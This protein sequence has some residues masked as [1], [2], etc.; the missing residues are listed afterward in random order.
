[1]SLLLFT[2]IYSIYLYYINIILN[3]RVT[4]PWSSPYRSFS[5][6]VW[7]YLILTYST[8]ALVVYFRSYFEAYMNNSFT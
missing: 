3:S 8:L 4:A 6:N 5:V 1:M 7:A 2:I